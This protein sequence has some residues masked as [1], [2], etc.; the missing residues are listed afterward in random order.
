MK[1]SEL[2]NEAFTRNHLVI[3]MHQSVGLEVRG[4]SVELCLAERR[5]A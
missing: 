5:K 1:L 4:I 3:S 2:I